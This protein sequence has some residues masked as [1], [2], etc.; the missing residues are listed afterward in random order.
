MASIFDRLAGVAEPPKKGSRQ[1]TIKREAKGRSSRQK[2]LR[3]TK[4]ATPKKIKPSAE[5]I[6]REAEIDRKLGILEERE[7]Q[8]DRREKE[9]EKKLVELEGIKKEQL[10]RL[11]RAA[12]LTR[13]E[14]KKLILEATEKR[15]AGEVSRRIREAEEKIKAEADEK[16]QEIL[17]DAM[18]HGVTDYVAEYT[19]STVQLP[20]EEMKGR[21]IGR[22]G[23]NIRAFEQATGVEIE[24][25]ETNEI[26]LSSFDPV[27][28]EI[29]RRA[30]LRLIR[31]RR[32]QPARIEEVVEK[33]KQTMDKIL[34]EEGQR[35]CHTVKVYNLHSDL[36]KL[37]GRFK[38]RF[39]YGQ[40]MIA[41]TLEE[42]KIGVA[43]A[44]EIGANVTVVRLG[45]LLHDIGKVITDQEGTH[46]ELGVNVAKKYNLP[47]E[48]IAC[49]EEHHE[50][51]P[52]SSPESRIIWIADAA[53]GARP[54]ARYEPHEEYVKRMTQIE[55]IAGDFDGVEKAYA[56][57][58]GRDVRV[59]VN[60][61]EISDDELTV[62]V[63]KIT[64]KL[65]KEIQYAGQIKVS[66]IRE[67][68]VS[69][70]TKAK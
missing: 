49:I 67:M 30:L 4:R 11:E 40:N 56:Y 22:E 10:A 26:H 12:K 18:Q 25:G 43:I 7:R 59:L 8:I 50:D 17:T 31:D 57:Q 33:T 66:G 52:F 5:I 42:T 68:R 39:S 32:I 34:L 58:A 14:A 9:L 28:R 70:T 16:A 6:R 64:E 41:H 35:L 47:P 69:G 2:P 15:L 13:E 19:V 44:A 1:R 48:V 24:L 29:A 51:K 36:V 38:F 55:K 20:N 27:R 60:P 45:C 65:E 23:R 37:L 63:N 46:V 61:Q 62:L 53:S 54:G 21:I 3:L